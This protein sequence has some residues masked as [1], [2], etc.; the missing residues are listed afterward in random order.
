[1]I[2]CNDSIVIVL[3]SRFFSIPRSFPGENSG[4]VV[5]VAEAVVNPNFYQPRGKLRANT[6]APR[7][8]LLKS[9]FSF[10]H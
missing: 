5:I 9:E 10:E 7:F 2:I 8:F 6:R 4:F 1:M 3:F